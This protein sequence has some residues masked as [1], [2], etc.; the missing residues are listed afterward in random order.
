MLKW[1]TVPHTYR[2]TDGMPI[3]LIKATEPICGYAPWFFFKI[4]ALYKSFTYLLTHTMCDVWP[5]QPQTYGCLPSHT[6]Q[7]LPRDWPQ[8]I[9]TAPYGPAHQVA[10]HFSSWTWQEAELASC[11]TKRRQ[12]ECTKYFHFLF[13]GGTDRHTDSH[14]QYTFRGEMCIGHGYLCVC[15]SPHSHTT[16]GTWM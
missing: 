15:P 12:Q 1:Q 16:A 11:T 10:T 6:T 13:Q 3:F 8:L 4:S 2:S 9:P 5:V 7:S 14:G